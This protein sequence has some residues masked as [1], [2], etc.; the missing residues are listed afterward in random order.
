M[1]RRSDAGPKLTRALV[2]KFEILAEKP[3]ATGWIY[4]FAGAVN[5]RSTTWP[6]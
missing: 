3:G 1:P 2:G 5:R 4:G 6:F